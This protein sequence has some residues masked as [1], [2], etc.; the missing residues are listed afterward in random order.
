MKI[1]KL[2]RGLTFSVT[3]A[4]MFDWTPSFFFGLDPHVYSGTKLI[5]LPLI[6]FEIIINIKKYIKLH[7]GWLYFF[8]LI[9]GVGG[10]VLQENV[11]F[12][13]LW[14][15]LPTPIVL[16]FYL[17][18]RSDEEVLNILRI[19][20]WCSLLV[21]VSTLL[22]FWGIITPSD[23]KES[24]TIFRVI[25]G[26]SWSSFGIYLIFIP[27]TLGGIFLVQDLNK[28]KI[29]DYIIS[30]ALIII[31][32]SACLLTALRSVGGVYI[33]LLC[34]S[35]FLFQQRQLSLRHYLR[36]IL[37]LCIVLGI[38]FLFRSFLSDIMPTTIYRFK[39]IGEED[40]S[41][42]RIDQYQLLLKDLLDLDKPHFFPIGM[43]IAIKGRGPYMQ[44]HSILGEAFYDGGLILMLV[45]LWGCSY[46]AY[47]M[48]KTWRNYRNISIAN[49]IIMLL[50]L[51][52]GCIMVLFFQPGLH[53]RIVYIILGLCLSVKKVRNLETK[54][55]PYNRRCI[56]YEQKYI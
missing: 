41:L 30:G 31:G 1:S 21:P 47:R 53:T 32:L 6:I 20:F 19:C 46:G 37:L 23:L 28:L 22:A 34:L 36:I 10:G 17:K 42:A 14:E 11:P 39:I 3:V 5:A 33:I 2:T 8:A 24:E 13:R 4:L 51:I 45:L 44:I 16:L 25:G 29:K 40:S 50:I 43:D 56:T 55:K 52:F 27:A 26:V 7:Y 38:G 12:Q 48:Y 9:V 35:L 18:P 15:L 54:L 49:T